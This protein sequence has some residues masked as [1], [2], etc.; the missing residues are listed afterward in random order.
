MCR[1]GAAFLAS[2][3]SLSLHSTTT[4]M[5]VHAHEEKLLVQLARICFDGFIAPIQRPHLVHHAHVATVERFRGK[6]KV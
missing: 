5:S 1:M 6:T 2:D 4:A 3:G